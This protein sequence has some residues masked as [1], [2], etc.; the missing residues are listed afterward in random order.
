MIKLALI[1]ITVVAP[2]LM[3]SAQRCEF[4]TNGVRE[5]PA[6]F[7]TIISRGETVSSVKGVGT[8]AKGG[9][10]VG[11]T[12][13]LWR[14][15]GAQKPLEYIGTAIAGDDGIFCFGDQLPGS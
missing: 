1:G 9:A 10:I 3:V 7:A 11:A 2:S 13:I 5:V 12:L 14:S 4:V 6:V 15:R 8:D